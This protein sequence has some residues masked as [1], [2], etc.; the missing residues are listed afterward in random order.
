MLAEDRRPDAKRRRAAWASAT[1]RPSA[2]STR[3]GPASAPAGGI[4]RPSQVF[5]AQRIAVQGPVQ[6]AVRHRDRRAGR[7]GRRPA[8]SA[9]GRQP[10]PSRSA[11]SERQGV[12]RRRRPRSGVRRSASRWAPQPSARARGRGPGPG[13]RSRTSPSP[14]AG[15]GR[16]SQ[17]SRSS[18]RTVTVDRLERRRAGPGGPGRRRVVPA[19]FL[20]RVLRRQLL[21]RADETRQ[22]RIDRRVAGSVRRRFAERHAR[23]RRPCRSRSRDGSVAS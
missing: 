15:P 9:G 10:G 13:R 18:A 19:D 14:A 1:S 4:H 7:A 3:T 12:L 21:E 11:S 6:A 22:R 16:R 2:A 20:G 5:W 23:P 17:P 8:R